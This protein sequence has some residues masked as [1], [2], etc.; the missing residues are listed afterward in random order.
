MIFYRL[1]N[2]FYH[3]LF[4]RDHMR[5]YIKGSLAFC[6]LLLTIRGISLI[7]WWNDNWWESW[8]FL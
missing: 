8:G 4:L 2:N 3:N 5:Q 7:W 6:F 1:K